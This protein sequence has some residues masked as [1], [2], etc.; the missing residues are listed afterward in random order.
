MILLEAILWIESHWN[1][2][3]IHVFQHGWYLD[4]HNFDGENAREVTNNFKTFW[5]VEL[6]LSCIDLAHFACHY[7][8]WPWLLFVETVVT[9]VCS[10]NG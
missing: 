3:P 4:C 10:Y 8:L 6:Q 5:I 9:C 7:F 1:H 2:I